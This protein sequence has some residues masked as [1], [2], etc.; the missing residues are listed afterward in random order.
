[1]ANVVVDFEP[2]LVLYLDLSYPLHGFFHSF[3]GGT[4]TAFLLA[5]V[6]RYLRKALSPIMSFLRLEQRSSFKSV[7][8][9]SLFGVYLHISLDSRLY[10]DIR[11]FYPFDFNPLLS[12]G[13]FAGFEIYGLCTLSFIC[14]GT[15]YLVKLFF[16]RRT[17]K[18][19][20]GVSI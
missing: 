11:P 15:V 13:M 10:Q 8:F 18:E 14:G 16:W 9:A 7:L 6:M 2:F 3:L 4:F 19:R 17:S 12:R 5:I 1:L 20:L